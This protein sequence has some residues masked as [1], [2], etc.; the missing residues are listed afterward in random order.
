MTRAALSKRCPTCPVFDCSCCVTLESCAV[1][2]WRCW[3]TTSVVFLRL[4]ASSTLKFSICCWTKPAACRESPDWTG[5]RRKKTKANSPATTI[6]TPSN[7][8][9]K[10]S[11]RL[12]HE[13]DNKNH[14]CSGQA[15]IAR[16]GTGLLLDPPPQFRNN[17]HYG[18]KAQRGSHTFSKRQRTAV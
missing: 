10:D 8:A 9:I 6:N 15:E 7:M 1:T 12:F 5:G 18:S 2:I 16:Q 14:R 11:K 3:L 13:E 4:E 17:D